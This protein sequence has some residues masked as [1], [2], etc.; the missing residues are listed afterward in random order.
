MK[1]LKRKLTVSFN[2]I[3]FVSVYF[4]PITLSN[5]RPWRVEQIPNG[6]KFG[7][8]NC[9]NSS[10]GGSLNSFGLSVE[11]VVGRGSRASFWNSVLASKDS[12]GDGS[13]NGEELGDPDGDGKSTDGA[14]ITNPS[15]PESKP[16]KP[17][18]PVVPELDIQKS[19]SP[20]SFNF[21]TVKGQKYEVQAT[22]DLRNWN[23]VVTIEGTGLE[24][25]FTDYREA[26]FLRQ[27]Y[28]VKVKN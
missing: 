1:H 5:A 17:V 28:R 12:D 10:Y 2:I 21:E 13:S 3:L 24:I 15:N 25:M 27:F 6:N 18:E 8:L 14:E 7:C 4:L 20:F 23:L 11:S 16:Q 22:N 26:L 19:K 9:H